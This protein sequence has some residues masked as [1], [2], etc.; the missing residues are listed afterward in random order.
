MVLVVVAGGGRGKKI[1]A[2]ILG[3]VGTGCGWGWGRCH[4]PSHH[5]PHTPRRL[6]LFACL[7]SGAEEM[8]CDY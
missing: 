5:D 3:V 2:V 7:A 6:V 1:Q 8:R 4:N